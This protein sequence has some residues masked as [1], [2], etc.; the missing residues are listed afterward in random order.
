MLILLTSRFLSFLYRGECAALDPEATAVPIRVVAE[1]ALIL[2]VP[3][4]SAALAIVIITRRVCT[5]LTRLDLFASSTW[6]CPPSLTR[7]PV[8]LES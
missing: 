5:V 2:S 6:T 4:D 3:R 8:P 7:F 1:L